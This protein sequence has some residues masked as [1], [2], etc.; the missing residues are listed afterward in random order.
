MF[1]SLIR[2][3]VALAALLRAAFANAA[4]GLIAALLIHWTPVGQTTEPR[5]AAAK[6]EKS[7]AAPIGDDLAGGVA[8]KAA[9]VGHALVDR[10][11]A[12]NLRPRP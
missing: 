4:L 6:A 3:T 2:Q 7:F 10:L 11:G 8:S 12:S 9:S 5:Q 1:E